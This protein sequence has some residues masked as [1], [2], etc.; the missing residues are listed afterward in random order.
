MP[1]PITTGFQIALAGFMSELSERCWYA[2]W[3]ADTEYALWAIV[4]N[5]ESDDWGPWDSVT[6]LDCFTLG[7]LSAKCNGWIAWDDNKGEV[8]VS[9]AE[10]LEMYKTHKFKEPIHA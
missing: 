3:M 7:Q 2:G 10:W 8:F 5:A 9:M 6:K 4:N 1:E